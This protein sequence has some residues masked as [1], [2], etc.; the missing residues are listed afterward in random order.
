MPYAARFI[1]LCLFALVLVAAL[2]TL[3]LSFVGKDLPLWQLEIVLALAS[4]A[5]S[6]I[7][8]S[9]TSPRW[10]GFRNTHS[11]VLPSMNRPCTPP[12]SRCA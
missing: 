8:T 7:A 5:A 3:A 9:S 2:A 11:L 4:V 12:P 6:S 1:A 10:R